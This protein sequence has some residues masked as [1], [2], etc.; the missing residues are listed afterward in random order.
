[1]SGNAYK[2]EWRCEGIGVGGE[3]LLHLRWSGMFF[4]TVGVFLKSSWNP[5]LC[6]STL[7]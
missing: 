7:V 3:E 5:V 2:S 1:M 4:P 6:T